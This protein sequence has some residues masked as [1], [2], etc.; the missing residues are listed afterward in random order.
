M[1]DIVPVTSPKPTDC[2]AT[3]M[4]MLLKYYDI[5]VDLDQL[6]KECNTGIS[7]CSGKDL[8]NCGRLHGQ[9]MRAYR[10]DADEVARQDRPSIIWW[11]YNHWSVCCGKDE[12]G[13]VVICN[14]DR[15]RYR[16]SAA[17]FAA[18]Y[19]GVAL[20]SGEPHDL[21]EVSA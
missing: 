12:N 6:A 7:G 18:M 2:G 1:F 9:D 17:T 13:Q 16:M 11:K 5:D 3:C 8:L 4:K 15:G 21:P 14:P 19:T 20:F 10:M